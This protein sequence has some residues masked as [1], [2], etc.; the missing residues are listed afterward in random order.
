MLASW[1]SSRVSAAVGRPS[2]TASSTPDFS[3][4][5]H[6]PSRSAIN[7]Q[8]ASRYRSGAA[9]TPGADSEGHP[10][11]GMGR[12]SADQSLLS[13]GARSTGSR[14]RPR[15]QRVPRHSG[16]AHIIIV[17]VRE[18][19][20]GLRAWVSAPPAPA[21]GGA[22][23]SPRRTL[24]VPSLSSCTC[25]RG[26]TTPRRTRAPSPGPRPGER[27]SSGRSP[28]RGDGPIESSACRTPGT[29]CCPRP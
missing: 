15:G 22:S 24:T 8:C 1:R 29:A 2:T 6:W 4:G 18:W 11:P 16:A 13:V 5:P 21:I 7:R 23:R 27:S 9:K 12:A 14:G 28:C 19:I 17:V 26:R 20:G 10:G 3:P 25:E